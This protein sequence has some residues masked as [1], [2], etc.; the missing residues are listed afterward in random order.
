M[1]N[2]KRESKY[3]TALMKALPVLA[4]TISIAM[5]YLLDPNSFETTWQGR[6][7]QFFF[8]WLCLLELILNWD[9]LQLIKLKKTKSIRSILF[10]VSLSLPTIY[11]IIA[12]FFG[13]NAT[14]FEWAMD[15]K[16]GE[17]WAR[18]IPLSTEYLVFMGLF[19]LIVVL[20]HGISGLKNYSLPVLF[21]GIIGGL[22]T[23]DN[24]YPWGR[25][26]PFQMIIPATTTLAASVLNL[27]GYQTSTFTRISSQYGYL[28]Y[29]TAQNS[30]G[31]ATFG[32]AWPCAGIESLIIYTVTILLFLSKSP[33]SWKQ[34]TAYFVFGGIMT[35]FI[36]ALRIATI[37]V[38]AINASWRPDYMPQEVQRFHD[39][40]GMLYSIIWIVFYPLIIIGSQTLWAK[41]VDRKNRIRDNYNLLHQ[42]SLN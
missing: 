32:I 34:K 25:F 21:V 9:E 29:L 23:V 40:Y 13:L 19:A 41:I 38:I 24:L 35:Y 33:I 1:L 31:A 20:E 15:S 4:F 3:I 39:Y 18:L 14:I 26:T 7:Y 27:I 5:L 6:T 17:H 12:N 42:K 36:N 30:K 37:F 10:A 28:P 22:Y 2:S 8:L 11:V 16:V